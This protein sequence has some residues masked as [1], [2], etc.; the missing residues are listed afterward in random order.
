MIRIALAKGKMLDETLAVFERAK[1]RPPEDL[2][3]TR[4]L[5]VPDKANDLVWMVVRDKDVPTYVSNGAADIGVVGR[6][7]L[8][9]SGAELYQILDLGIG[10]CRL[11][12]A[13]PD[14]NLLKKSGTLRIATKFPNLTRDFFLKKG[15]SCSVIPLYGS[16][17]L[18]PLVNLADGIIDLVSTGRTLE[19]NNLQ[20]IEEI[21]PSTAALVANRV[22]LKM[23][24]IRIE[25]LAARVQAVLKAP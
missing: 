11:V 24:K 6:D 25:A 4:K 22:S 14:P 8:A 23:E 2:R 17:E 1:I 16:V 9:E 21:M 15:V 18:A 3:N 20:I 13:A 5:V 10:Y 12:L 19:E 7:V